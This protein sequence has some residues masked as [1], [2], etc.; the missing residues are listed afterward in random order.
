MPHA[1]AFDMAAA[2]GCPVASFPQAYLGL[3]LSTHK[4][5]AADLAPIIS[6]CDK[7]LAGWRGRCTPIGG[8]LI[9]VNSVLSALLSHAM[10]AGILPIGSIEAID[11]RRRAF[12]WIGEDTCN[13]GNCK[14]AWKDVCTPKSKGGLGVLCLSSQ[15]S[16][17]ISKF[18]SKI[19]GGS[20]APWASWFRRHYGWHAS[21]DLGDTHHLDTPIWKDIVSTLSLF[22]DNSTVNI[23]SGDHTSFWFDRW[24][25]PNTL[26]EVFPALASHASR[27]HISVRLAL[28]SD[29]STFL[30]PRLSNVASAELASIRHLLAS[31]SLNPSQLRS[32]EVV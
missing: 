11:K 20:S 8:R 4:F 23:G 9:L 15:N 32:E 3:P 17:L 24:T 13:G 16:S 30:A 22:R 26:A 27:P 1:A 6:R 21:R 29:L 31:F 25:G 18:L 12:F 2:F 10:A 7:Y 28:S 5:R 19:H 14:V